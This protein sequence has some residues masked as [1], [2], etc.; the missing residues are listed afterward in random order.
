MRGNPQVCAHHGEGVRSIPAC[1]GEPQAFCFLAMYFA[2]YPRVCGGTL[3]RPF[4]VPAMIGLSPRVRGNRQSV[5]AGEYVY[6]SIPACAGEPGADPGPGALH[7]VYPCVCGGTVPPSRLSSYYLGLS[8]RVRGN[9]RL[10]RERR[11]GS[12]SIPACAGEPVRGT[13]SFRL[14]GVYPRVCGG[15]SARST[16]RPSMAGLSPRVRGNPSE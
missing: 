10:Q 3:F 1:V 16:F 15:T 5:E 12:G 14:T 6:R 13:P 8:P 7:P 11:P 4:T 2:V 9:Q